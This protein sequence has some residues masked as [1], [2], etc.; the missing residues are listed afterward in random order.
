MIKYPLTYLS[1]YFIAVVIFRHS[2]VAVDLEQLT[3]SA[4]FWTLLVAI[5]DLK[6][7]TK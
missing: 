7:G 6:K 2:N 4:M 1:I 5:N 3:Q